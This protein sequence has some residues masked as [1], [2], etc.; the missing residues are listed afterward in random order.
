MLLTLSFMAVFQPAAAQSILRDAETEALFKDMSRP[1][2]EAAGLR[3]ENVDI[4]LVND[5]TI[6]AFVAGGQIVYIHSGLIQ[7]ADNANEVQGV[8]AHELGHVTGGHVIRYNQGAGAATGITVLSLLL[9]VAAVAAGAGEAGAGIMAAGQQ[10]AMGKFLAFLQSEE[11][12][13]DQAGANYLSG[14]GVSGKGSLSFF[15]KLQ[16]QEFRLALSQEDGYGRTH[17]LTGQRM[18][19]LEARYK[20]D[21]AWDKKTDPALEARFQR[22]KAKLTGY[23][24]TPA[25]TLIAYPETNKSVPARYARA[26]AYHKSAFPDKAVAEV[27]SLLKDQPHDPYF[28]EL[29]G[30]IL[31]ESGKPADALAS[32]RDAVDHA[33]DQP[34]IA[35]LFGHALIATEDPANF[36]EAEKV[37]RAAVGRDN[38]NPFAWYQLGIIYDREGDAGRAALATA[39]R[40]NLEG[41]PKLAL[42]S[43]EQA[44]HGIPEGSA[45]W[46]RAQDIKLV[47][48]AAI[49]KDKKK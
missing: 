19:W 35:A 48:E 8:I 46:V 28:L 25:Q 13:A 38:S 18:Q 16:N 42:A 11:S 49:K 10:A 30:Q 7:A 43:A 20:A 6:N 34:L 9:G 23:V 3:P 32:L 33:P 4:V 37:L 21:P 17:P 24:N 26:Y 47:S 45:D 39:E 44:M 2:I 40:Y 12:S 14:A 27:D 31:L 41:N 22:V 1:I 36:A 29:K 5:S 15:K